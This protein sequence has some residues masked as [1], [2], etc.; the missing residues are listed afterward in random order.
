MSSR[1]SRAALCFQRLILHSQKRNLAQPHRSVP[2]GV[3]RDRPRKRTLAILTP[4]APAHLSRGSCGLDINGCRDARTDSR[5]IDA[6]TTTIS[7]CFSL[8]AQI[9]IYSNIRAVSISSASPDACTSA[10]TPPPRGGNPQ[11]YPGACCDRR[12]RPR[13]SERRRWR[14]TAGS[15]SRRRSGR[16]LTSDPGPSRSGNNDDD[17]ARRGVGPTW[18]AGAIGARSRRVRWTSQSRRGKPRRT[19]GASRASASSREAA[20]HGP[21]TPKRHFLSRR[22]VTTPRVRR[23]V[24]LPQDRN[25][26]CRRRTR[27]PG[28]S[29]AASSFPSGAAPLSR[30]PR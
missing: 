23:R 26:G 28:G 14:R 11:I 3:S 16:R 17:G 20:G 15:S 6:S 18:P 27:R 9:Q 24:S 4:V 25:P 8:S 10:Q 13:G 21:P 29:T 22:R 5:T 12:P 30:G 19:R 1:R 2:P 7:R